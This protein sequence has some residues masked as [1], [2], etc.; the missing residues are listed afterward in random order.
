MG[1]L[2]GYSKMFLKRNASTILTCA[3]GI[4]VVA[5]T[6]VAVKTTPKVI[7]LLEEAKEEKGEELTKLETIKVAGPSYIPAIAIGAATI[8]CIAGANILNKKQQASLMSAYALLD[9]SYKEHKDK[10]VELFGEDANDKIKE[11]IAK[12]RYEETDI[13]VD[14]DKQLFYDEFSER[15]FESTMEKVV[16]AE[17]EI[18]RK[19]SLWGGAH[20][21]EFYEMLD[22]PP[23]PGG[24]SL[25]WSEACL[26]DMGWTSWLDFQHE[27]AVMDDGLECYIIST[28]FEPTVDYYYY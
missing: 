28:P 4:G 25:G 15:Y 19:I 3:G 27:K 9:A 20:V 6:I 11:S 22:I 10:V 13:S 23:I 18:N 12:D 5:T 21:N 2:L 8:A 26:M 7:T 14:D 24:E 1:N 17:Y 16:K